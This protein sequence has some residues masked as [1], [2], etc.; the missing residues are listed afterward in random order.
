MSKLISFE[1]I[2]GCGKTTQINLI[3]SLL[4]EKDIKHTVIREPGGTKVSED[5]R[6][7]LLDKKNYISKLTETLLFLSARSQVVEEII[8]PKLKSNEIVLC[9]R[10]IDSTTA[11]Q[12][13]GH[14][15]DISLI[16]NINLFSISNFLP[17]LTIYFDIDP[18]IAYDRLKKKSLDRMELMGLDYLCRVR[19]GYL[20]IVDLNPNRF[21]SIDC[22]HLDIIAVNNEVLNMI[23]LH[24]N[25]EI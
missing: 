11:Y 13:Y 19:E 9:D 12:G 22:N 15:L 16:E 7:I 14:N 21:K 23:E 5:I 24:L 20:K 4:K 8:K 3:S 1:G 6:D 17:D 2:D 18:S 10:Y 25:K